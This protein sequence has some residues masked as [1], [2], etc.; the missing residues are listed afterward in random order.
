MR[1]TALAQKS[2]HLHRRILQLA[3][4]NILTNITVPLLG[5]VD[6]A[7]AGHLSDATAIAAVAMA[8][9]I[10]NLIY[11][12]FSFLRMGTTGLTAQA[13]GTGSRQ[14]M[15]RLLGQSSLIAMVFG[16]LLLLFQ[17]PILELVLMLLNPATEL[18]FYASTYYN[19]VIW[20]AP[21]ILGTYALNG[22]LIGMQNT[23]YPMAVS[24]ITNVTNIAISATL[25]LGY[26]WEIPGLALGT[27]VAQWVGVL[28]LGLGAWWLFLRK[29]VVTLPR[30][31]GEL[32]KGLRKFFNTNVHIY[33][34]TL[35]LA[36]ISLYFTYVGTQEGALVLAANALLY[37]FFT[38]FSY[39]IDGFAYA[40]EALVGHYFGRRD[41]DTLRH[42]IRI[43]MR[44]GAVLAVTIS[45][46]YM[47]GGESF[48][49]FLTDKPEVIAIAKRYL[50]WVYLVPIAGFAAFLY[51]GIFIGATASRQMLWSMAVAVAVFFLLFF[52]KPLQLLV[53][54][55]T[56]ISHLWL[57]YIAFLLV[58]GWVQML[59]TRRLEGIGRPFRNYF[60][61][62][63]GS[64]KLDVEEKI[65]RCVL[66]FWPKGVFSPFY[67][68]S[69][70]TGMTDREYLNAVL[71]IISDRSPDELQAE[72]KTIEDSAGRCRKENCAEVTL[73]LDLI[74]SEREIFRAREFSQP[75]FQ[76][77]FQ[78]FTEHAH[79]VRAEV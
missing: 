35:L 56:P 54:N 67:I 27:V 19:I 12:N 2:R 41:R 50:P 64:T 79:S 25:V 30:R 73:D 59:M 69:D 66:G 15:G 20:G 71:Q 63:V 23:W 46:I 5:M 1:D 70:G 7:L 11:W 48:L 21:A 38:F 78:H 28:L 37:Q 17:R 40:A 39:F 76:E 58:R 60:Y 51:D 9:T 4:P 13:N 74:C 42:V 77:G 24:I 55:A 29:Q 61:F 18:R 65:K 49:T 14:A 26:G 31:G 68:S 3:L 72:A 22:W 34:R 44:W 43:L 8:T 36:L 62:L 10:F 57:A 6:L 32:L 75:H 16:V 45:A 33:F 52:G 53:P 47:L